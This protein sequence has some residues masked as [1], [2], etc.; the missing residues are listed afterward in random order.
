MATPPIIVK[1]STATMYL[2]EVSSNKLTQLVVRQN[3]YLLLKAIE[4]ERE[5]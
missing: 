4:G 1:I 2:P 3:R 5:K